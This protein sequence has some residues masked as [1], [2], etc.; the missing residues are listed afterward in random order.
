MSGYVFQ[1][2]L[3]RF[4]IS[5][6][7]YSCCVYV[8][9]FCRVRGGRPWFDAWNGILASM[10]RSMIFSF[11]ETH[12]AFLSLSLDRHG[13]NIQ[14]WEQRHFLL[15]TTFSVVGLRLGRLRIW[16]VRGVRCESSFH[17][18]RAEHVEETVNET[19]FLLRK[20]AVTIQQKNDKTMHS[21]GRS[22]RQYKGWCW[23]Q[24]RK[25]TAISSLRYHLQNVYKSR[26][27]LYG[28]SAKYWCVLSLQ[29]TPALG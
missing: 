12:D 15:P 16:K 27:W 5:Q 6:P 20:R 18:L 13:T 28:I 24:I 29:T 11:G 10:K 26:K 21:V 22:A 7:V 8:F 2:H 4:W 3:L 25:Q 17:G 9:L 14:R 19:G 1:L 23:E